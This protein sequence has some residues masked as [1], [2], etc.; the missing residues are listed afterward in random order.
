MLR[1]AFGRIGYDQLRIF[2]ASLSIFFSVFGGRSRDLYAPQFLSSYGSGIYLANQNH[3]NEIWKVNEKKKLSSLG[4][5]EQECG[6]ML[7]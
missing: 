2:A 4:N 1:L 5:C 3:L 7:V 6:Q